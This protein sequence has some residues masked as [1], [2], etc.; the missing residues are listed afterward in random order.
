MRIKKFYEAQEQILL[1][2]ETLNEMIDKIKEVSDKVYLDRIKDCNNCDRFIK[3]SKQCK[4]CGCIMT[5]KAK[6]PHAACP[7]GK[8]GTSFE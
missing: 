3:L 2:N 8:W 7:I 1:S 4:E 6:L 5:S